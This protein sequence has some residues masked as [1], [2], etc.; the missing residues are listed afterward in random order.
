MKNNAS[1]HLLAM[2]RVSQRAIA[3]HAGVSPSTVSRVLNNVEGI[4]EE[5]RNHVLKSA[6]ELGHQD[7]A[8][9]GKLQQLHLFTPSYATMKAPHT[10]HVNILDGVAAECRQHDILLNY[11]VVEQSAADRANILAQARGRPEVGILLVSIDDRELIEELLNLKT[12]VVLINAEQRDLAIDT[13]LPNNFI[14]G[15]QATRHLLQHGHRL[16]L[17]MTE[18]ESKRRSTLQRRLA[19]YRAALEEAHIPYDPAYLLESQLKVDDAHHMMQTW[20][21]RLHPPFSAVFCANDASAIGVMRAL[22]EAGKRIPEDISVIGYDDVPAASLLIPSLTTLH[23]NSEEM[24]R[25]A[26]QRMIYRALQPEAAPIRVEITSQ[27]II[28]QSVS[29]CSPAVPS[30][31]D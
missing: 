28:R 5:L 1:P 26:V 17:H 15:L 30:Q 25:L 22:Q 13:F 9:P 19:G 11:S 21:S 18:P 24:G 2:R 31:P 4:S 16:I 8:T 10:F 20:L 7:T 6:A 23:A 29:T 12:S 3:K 14:G 27:L